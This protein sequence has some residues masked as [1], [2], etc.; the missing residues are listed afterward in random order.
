[1]FHDLQKSPQI[2]SRDF[3]FIHSFQLLILFENYRGFDFG[4]SFVGFSSYD[5]ISE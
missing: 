2:I 1:M 4:T 5:L 3:T